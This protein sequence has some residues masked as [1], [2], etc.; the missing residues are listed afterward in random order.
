MKQFKRPVSSCEA[1][2]PPLC[3]AGLGMAAMHCASI[4]SQGLAVKHPRLAKHHSI[5]GRRRL[6]VRR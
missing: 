2:G 3:D 1:R 4:T 5:L 6:V